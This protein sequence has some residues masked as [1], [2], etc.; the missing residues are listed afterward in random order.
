MCE[1]PVLYEGEGSQAADDVFSMLTAYLWG[2]H[3]EGTGLK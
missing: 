3:F 1:V 2:Y